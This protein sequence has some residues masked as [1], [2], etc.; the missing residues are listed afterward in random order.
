MQILPVPFPF[1]VC[2]HPFL[3]VH[4]NHNIIYIY[5]IES[6]SQ[7]IRHSNFT[8]HLSSPKSYY[9][10]TYP[11]T[12]HPYPY[13]YLWQEQLHAP[14]TK[15]LRTETMKIR[16]FLVPARCG[17]TSPCLSLAK[18]ATTLSPERALHPLPTRQQI[19]LT[20]RTAAL[21][22]ITGFFIRPTASPSRPLLDL[23]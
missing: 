20:T 13:L 5:F 18:R 15:A 12:P 22:Y 16:Y 7:P 3:Y 6:T 14:G 11:F 19:L 2:P 23:L 1:T 9:F 4:T 8:P 21:R 10:P 17:T